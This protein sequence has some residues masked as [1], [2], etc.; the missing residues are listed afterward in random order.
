MAKDLVCGMDVKEGREA[1]SSLYK[2]QRYLF[3]SA[4]CKE[5]FDKDPDKYIKK[6]SGQECE[7]NSENCVL[8]PDYIHE[9]DK[10]ES[11]QHRTESMCRY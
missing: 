10:N 2:G 9:R 4:G 8:Q 3:C 5:K 7:N 1:G 6:E 11:S